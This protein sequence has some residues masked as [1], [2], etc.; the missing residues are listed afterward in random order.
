[1]LFG[2]KI[3]EARKEK[4]MT[5]EQ[6]AE[7]IGIAKSTLTGYEKGNREPDLLKIKKLISILEINPDYLFETNK[8]KEEK[9]IDQPTFSPDTLAVA[10]VYES[11]DIRTR[12]KVRCILDM[13][14]LEKEPYE[15]QDNWK[16]TS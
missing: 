7:K 2:E 11:A 6:L 5:Q 8:Y 3:A 10:G 12:N 13:D 14:L 9:P 1:M 15:E 16:E 4:G